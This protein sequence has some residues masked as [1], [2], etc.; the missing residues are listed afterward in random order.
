[1]RLTNDFRSGLPVDQ[2]W[3]TITD[4]HQLCELLPGVD[5]HADGPESYRG[6]I[7][8]P[9]GNDR[10]TYDSTATVVVLDP[11]DR[12]CVLDV[13]G[14]HIEGDGGF[15]ATLTIRVSQA[16]SDSEVYLEADMD[17]TG[18]LVRRGRGAVGD[19]VNHLVRDLEDN[20]PVRMHPTGALGP[21]PTTSSEAAEV[22]PE[23]SP[24]AHAAMWALPVAGAVSLL[25]L[26]WRWISRRSSQ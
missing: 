18:S 3:S 8:V 19:V 20:L 16:G 5:L 14:V 15:R 17:V 1:M 9:V 10:M 21:A 12:L 23:H 4:L 11:S 26:A 24:P 13:E 22:S 7:S 6:R 25:V 2:L